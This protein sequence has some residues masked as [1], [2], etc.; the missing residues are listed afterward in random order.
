[1]T[2]LAKD[3]LVGV[4]GAGAMGSGIAQVA[5]DAGHRVVL[6]DAA[7][8]AIEH[9]LASIGATYARLVEKGKI[10][11]AQRDER[12]ARL[13]A[14]PELRQLCD[15]GLVIEAIIENLDIKC[16]LLRQVEALL[17][18][19]A[20]IA[21][22]TS[23]LSVT[24]IAARL[25]CPE[26][27]VGMH[28]FNPAPLL[29]LVEVVHGKA[30]SE[31]VLATIFD[32]A[33]DWGKVPVH[34]SSTPG[35]IVNRVARPFY[36]EA[37]RLLGE[38]AGA[39]PTIDAVLRGAGG[40]RM[41][42]FELMD[43]IGHDVNYAVTT[44]VYD[45][46][47][48]DARYTPSLLQKELV[49]AGWLGRKSGRG[50]YDYCADAARAAVPLLAAG[51]APVELVVEGDVG[52]AASLVTLAEEAGMAVR[53][54]TGRGLLRV[55]GVTLALTDG[56]SCSERAASD[57]PVDVVFDLALDYRRADL[58]ALARADQAPAAALSVAAGF[59]AL[60]GK[61][62]VELDDAPGL[63][64]MRTV[65]MLVNESVELVQQGVA[66]A[67]A[68]DLA[69]TKGVNY[70]LGPLAW[71]DRIGA[72]R[73]ADVIANLAASYGEDRYRVAPLLRRMSLSNRL[74]FPT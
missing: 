45:G 12:L 17:A 35:F 33:L 57:A 15:A 63:V 70:P 11:A 38:R 29:P 18:P 40:F 64:V 37:L 48:Q 68:V 8:A 14:G 69:M 4:I 27:V 28:F 55:D 36:A 2:A 52:P 74:F 44:S 49:D 54:T 24:A 42:A 58:V 41:G 9:A 10:S 60:L 59:F 62:A 66:D 20:I 53:F 31:A 71:C 67:A 51:A 7:P 72:A 46:M 50:F 3:V 5:L 39:V 32:T 16:G 34:C 19:H 23:S 43:M 6:H 25:A 61:S 47:Y 73:V 1:M 21:T 13:C 65:A 22:N 30:T 56:R 26:R